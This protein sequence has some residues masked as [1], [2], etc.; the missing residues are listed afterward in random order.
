MKDAGRPLDWHRAFVRHTDGVA[1]FRW[2]ADR[3]GALGPQLTASIVVGGPRWHITG[4][5]KLNNSYN[6]P[7][8]FDLALDD[9]NFWL[10]AS[11]A[12]DVD[13]VVRAAVQRIDAA[14]RDARGHRRAN[15]NVPTPAPTTPTPMITMPGVVAHHCPTADA[16]ADRETSVPLAGFETDGETSM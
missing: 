2:W 11:Q 10:F 1:R 6:Q 12:V 4:V 16:K 7:R 14:V 9:F 5:V 13:A 3:S 15:T 8:H